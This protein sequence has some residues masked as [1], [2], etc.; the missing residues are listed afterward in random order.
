MNVAHR[1]ATFFPART[2]YSVKFETAEL[3][4]TVQLPSAY[5]SV[6]WNIK[7]KNSKLIGLLGARGNGNRRGTW[8]WIPTVQ[9]LSSSDVISASSRRRRRCLKVN[10]GVVRRR[11][12]ALRRTSYHW[13]RIQRRIRNIQIRI[14]DPRWWQRGRS[15][16]LFQLDNLQCNYYNN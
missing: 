15:Q 11:L 8:Q 1:P 16:D 2:T 5:C 7:T 13:R 6:I 4:T 12:V 9:L 3:N 14:V 10:H